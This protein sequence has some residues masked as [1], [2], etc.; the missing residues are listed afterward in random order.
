[1]PAIQS[2]R[3]YNDPALGAA[4]SNLAA[5]FAPPSGSDLA[6]Y[7][8]ARKGNLQ[9]EAL[10]KAMGVYGDPNASS[11]VRDAA[12]VLA[13]LFTPT[14]GFGARNMESADR[15][16]GTDVVA[17]TSLANNAADNARELEQTRLNN[18]KDITTSML[19]PVAEGATRFVPGSIARMYGAS[20]TQV[21]AVKAGQGDMVVT[22]DGR[23][24]MGAPKPPTQEQVLGAIT[25]RLPDAD[26]RAIAMRDVKPENIIGPDGKPKIVS[27]TAAI[28]AG[29][30]PYIKP[31]NDQM[32]PLA[33]L[34]Q[35]RDAL[36]EGDPRRAA[37]DQNIAALGRGQQQ[38]AY[39]RANDEDL[40]KLNTS[41][42]ENA[43]NAYA[44]RG[45]Y[46]TVLAAVDNPTVDQGTLANAQ[47][48]LRKALN[49]FGVNMGNTAPAEL[50]N[51]LGGQ[52]AL[53]LRNQDGANMPGAM[54]DADRE[55][56]KTM[57]VSLQNSPQA[58]RLL[59]QYYLAAQQRA[60]DLNELRTTYIQQHG[61][62]DEG[63]RTVMSD[64]LGTADPT[65]QL[66]SQLAGSAAP[67]PAPAAR[68][69]QSTTASQP[70]RV[71]SPVE[72]AKLPSGTSIILPDGSMGRVP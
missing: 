69:R 71:S 35:E 59:A 32:S 23:T 1:M 50:L 63:F 25:G 41:T 67:A 29:A 10:Q 21:G 72:A 3:Y 64:Y 47:L 55:F 30:Q 51:A 54:S 6:G 38:S 70:V 37:Y 53:K 43:K 14:Q 58:N 13:G 33:R 20:E 52:I 66:R 49:A 11:D 27:S 12:G 56:L 48:G 68:P 31:T 46:K 62:I 28:D 36:P 42:F 5:A 60:I 65:A 24:I 19:A 9:A 45:L 22:P 4:F 2:N 16:Y 57:S 7:A 15:R 61:R 8:A 18:T 17:R 40:S 44:E 26:Q 34:I 39:D